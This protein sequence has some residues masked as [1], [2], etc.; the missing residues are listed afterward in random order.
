M[1]VQRRDIFKGNPSAD[2]R[3]AP[4]GTADGIGGDDSLGQRGIYAAPAFNDQGSTDTL[5]RRQA[6]ADAFREAQRIASGFD[7]DGAAGVQ[8]GRGADEFTR[9][10]QIATQGGEGDVVAPT[11]PGVYR[12]DGADSGTDGT[13]K[14][15]G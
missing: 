15:V 4:V 8:I 7:G 10:G 12:T 9:G 13:G 2:N 5:D 6:Q 1:T 14:A 11:G 3:L